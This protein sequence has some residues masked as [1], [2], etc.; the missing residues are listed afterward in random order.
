MPKHQQILKAI[1]AISEGKMILVTDAKHREDEADLIVAA[2]KITEEQMNFMVTHGRGL[3]CLAL[4]ESRT[5]ALELPLQLR[6]HAQSIHHHTA[7][8]VSIDARHGI[9][10]GISAHDRVQTVKVAIDTNSTPQDLIVPGHIFPLRAQNGGVLTRPGHTEAAIDLTQL[11][12][13]SP[14]SVICEVMADDGGMLRGEKLTAYAKKYELP[15]ISIAELIDYLKEHPLVPDST[16]TT[17][18]K[19]SIAATTPITTRFGEFTC[20][21]FFASPDPHEH[22]ALISGDLAK[23]SNPFV[24][25][26][27]EC[28]TGDVFGSLH[29][30]CGLQRDYA[31][32]TI[33]KDGGLFIYLR[34]EGRGIGL[35]NK[36]KA[37]SRQRQQNLD[38]VE[39]NL[40]LGLPIDCRNYLAAGLLLQH[41]GI[42]QCRLLT[43]NPDKLS[44]L[45]TYVETVTREA[46]IMEENAH[47]QKYL[48]TKASKLGH[49]LKSR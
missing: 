47:N 12:G 41:L 37:Y 17:E 14:A 8:T 9:K 30:D 48:M 43:N 11:A 25:I 26:H 2:E 35:T 44:A 4:T 39:A 42:K 40:A 29:C 24:R 38:T 13:L 31:M 46:I 18:T 28:L 15:L 20:L 23:L 34:Q 22:V 5:D 16:T 33:A 21:S 10:T 6:P 19:V 1:Q 36:L 45:S 3:V 7:F 49:W 32:Q 27:S